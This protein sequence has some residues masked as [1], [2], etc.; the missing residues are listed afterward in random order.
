[1]VHPCERHRNI[2]IWKLYF[3]GSGMNELWAVSPK[4]PHVSSSWFSRAASSPLLRLIY[5]LKTR[6]ST[7]ICSYYL[8][9]LDPCHVNSLMPSSGTQAWIIVIAPITCKIWLVSPLLRLIY[10]LK[11]RQSTVIC[12]Y[13]LIPLDPCHV[14]SLMPSSGTQA[15]IIVIAPIT[16]KIW[17]VSCV[18]FIHCL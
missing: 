6:Q 3:P 17:L 14:N 13:Y 11:T 16:C 18:D 8:I 15:W 10:S 4:H 9:P 5:S 2:T 7:V 12:S 1:M